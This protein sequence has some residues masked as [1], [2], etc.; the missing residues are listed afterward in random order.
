MKNDKGRL[1][2]RLAV[3]WWFI[4]PALLFY[5][6]VAVVPNLQAIVYSF[7]DWNGVSR[8][9]A[10]VGWEN[11]VRAFAN[12]NF[13]RGVTN[14]IVLTVLIT[15]VQMAGG[16]ALALLLAQ[17]MKTKS[18]LRT[19]FFT[20]VVLTSVAVAYIWKF[21]YAPT[22]VINEILGAVGLSFLQKDWLGD[23]AVNLFA[24]ALMCVWQSIGITMVIYLAGIEGIDQQ[25]IEATHLDGAGAWQRFWYVT[26]PLLAPA[27]LVN[28]VLC[29]VGGL[30]IFDQIFVTTQGG[31]ARST[32]TLATLTYTD[33]FIPGNYSYGVTLS[34]VLAVLVGIIS[35][36]QFR[37]MSSKER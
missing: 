34:V 10:F 15:I 28:A 2:S 36:V 18:L 13:V 5:V 25:V 31:P 19:L 24:I 17:R 7:T 12:P 6:L 33:G 1:R 4:V 22:G 16:L 30:R 20:P 27:T 3:P 23:P 8:D 29:V 37:L 11:Y 26:R 32:S 35:I 9:L 14:T 21:M